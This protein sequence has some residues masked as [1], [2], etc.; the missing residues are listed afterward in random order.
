MTTAEAESIWVEMMG[1]G[2]QERFYDVR[3]VRT[4]VWEA[5]AGPTLVM[6]HGTGGHAETYYRNI[7]PLSKRMH[8]CSVDMI[9][10][11]FTDRPDLEYTLDDYADHL[12]GL[13]DAMGIERV[14]LSGESLG[15]A[16]TSWFAITRP[17]RVERAVL[18]TG[19]LAAPDRLDQILE[20][21][22]R[23]RAI[24]ADG[25]TREAVRRRLE[26]LVSDPS[27]IT[28]ELVEVRYRIYSQPGMMDTALRIMARMMRMLG[29][30][31]GQHYIE[32]GVMN[33]VKCP[34]LVLWSEHNPGQSIE[35]ARGLADEMP[36]ARF[37]L[38]GDCGHWPQFERPELVN[39]LHQEFLLEP[40]AG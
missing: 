7:G 13:L 26:W 21:G 4:R 16:V 5:G 27:R 32:P 30:E 33:G 8:V 17:D 14:H 34:T 40:V 10:H 11:G 6:L 15:A 39:E 18:N 23:T 22:Q 25:L 31:V 35:L 37:E 1:H 20:V 12:E 36:D 24:M 29:G 3:G 38:L 28:D 19:I 2:V 9:G